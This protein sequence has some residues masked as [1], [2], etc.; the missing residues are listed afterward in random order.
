MEKRFKT[1]GDNLIMDKE[2]IQE[3]VELFR[4][5]SEKD[6]PVRLY[7]IGQMHLCETLLMMFPL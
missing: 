5:M 4:K 2:N 6:T 7:Y 1:D 3:L